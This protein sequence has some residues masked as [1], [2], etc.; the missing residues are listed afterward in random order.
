MQPKPMPARV[1]SFRGWDRPQGADREFHHGGVHRGSAD[2]VLNWCF[3]VSMLGRWMNVGPEVNWSETPYCVRTCQ[4]VS[5]RVRANGRRR[6]RLVATTPL[7]SRCARLDAI[8]SAQLA[9]PAKA[10]GGYRSEKPAADV[11]LEESR[12]TMRTRPP[13]IQ[14]P[15]SGSAKPQDSGF[16]LGLDGRCQIDGNREVVQGPELGPN[17]NASGPPSPPPRVG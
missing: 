14:T 10:S 6:Q 2:P 9:N 8:G 5:E 13:K 15:G 17:P 3:G 1:E 16:Y 7:D 4:V 11:Q 12:G